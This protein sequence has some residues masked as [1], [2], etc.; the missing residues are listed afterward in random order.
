MRFTKT[1]ATAAALMVGALAFGESAD[2]RP[3][4]E[5]IWRHHGGGHHGHHH[6][7]GGYYNGFGYGAFGFAA[8]ALLGSALSRP[9]YYE[10]AP[11]YVAPAP[12][13]VYQPWTPDWYTYCGGKYRSF[14]P[15][16]GYFLGYDG[17]YHFCR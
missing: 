3:R 1:I 5:R 15:D 8:G 13:Y 4:Q 10:P 7:H 12:V 16:T 11:V 17:E 14:N 6:G 2:A 9:Y